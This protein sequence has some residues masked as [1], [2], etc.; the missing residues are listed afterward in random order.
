M[1]WSSNTANR[2]GSASE[3]AAWS[4]NLAAEL[5]CIRIADRHADA[6][7]PLK[8]FREP[9]GGAVPPVITISPMPRDPGWFW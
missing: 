1:R 3:L 6:D 9:G 2:G 8:L 7:Q 5:H 4:A